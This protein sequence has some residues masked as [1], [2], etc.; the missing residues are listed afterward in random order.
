MQGQRIINYGLLQFEKKIIKF[1]KENEPTNWDLYE[2]ALING[3]KVSHLNAI[4]KKI[5]NLE[6]IPIQGFEK[7]RRGSFYIGYKYKKEKKKVKFVIND[8]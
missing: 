5:E 8:T 3:F 2:Y 1:V 4:L 7:V 6:V